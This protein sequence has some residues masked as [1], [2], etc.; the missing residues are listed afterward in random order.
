MLISTGKLIYGVALEPHCRFLFIPWVKS[1]GYMRCLKVR[2]FGSSIPVRYIPKNSPKPRIPLVSN[3]PKNDYEEQVK[4]TCLDPNVGGVESSYGTQ[5]SKRRFA[6]RKP[7]NNENSRSLVAPVNEFHE[8]SRHGSLKSDVLGLESVGGGNILA[9]SFGS[10]DLNDETEVDEELGDFQSLEDTE[11]LV[12]EI[13]GKETSG[14]P[15]FQSSKSNQD[16]ENT[17]AGFLSRRALTTVELRKK[18]IAKRYPLNV[19]DQVITKFQ[20]RKFLDDFQYA[21]AFSRSRFSSLSWGPGRI[22]QALRQKGVSEA[23][24]EK[25]IKL[26]FKDG[27]SGEDQSRIGLS[28]TSLDQLFAQA[29]KRWLQSESQ[30]VDKRKSKIIQWLRYRGYNWGVVNVVLK[31]LESAF[32]P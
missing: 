7:P 16:A 32:P 6:P 20:I 29:S 28:N 31:K 8:I 17:A 1:N 14:K 18:L 3:L 9:R 5:V 12:R 4:H 24:A 10:L 11:E 19:V 23:D 21:E 22:K 2:S 15:A 27:E 30:P 13:T 25:A 26:V